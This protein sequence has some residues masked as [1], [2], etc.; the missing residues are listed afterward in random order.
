MTL[1]MQ[2]PSTEALLAEI[3]ALR[4]EVSTLRREKADMELLVEMTVEYSDDMTEDLRQRIHTAQQ[5]SMRQ[6]ELLINATPVP[7]V[8]SRIAGDQ[9]VYANE[10]AAKLAGAPRAEL[11]GHSAAEFYIVPG[12]R[13]RLLAAVKAQG[14]VNNWEAEGRKGDNTLFW[15]VIFVRQISFRG[16]P[17]LLEAYHNRTEQK[18]AEQDR[19]RL[20]QQVIEAQRQSLQEL[21]SPIIPVIDV[22]ETG[23]II[24]VP[25]IGDIDSKRAQDITRSLLVGI[26]EHRA[27]VVILDITGVP[28]VNAD[29]A[30]H[31]NRTIQAARLKGARTIVTGVSDAVAE[32]IVDLGIDWGGIRTLGDLQAGLVA[33]LDIV[34]FKLAR[35]WPGK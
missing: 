2:T 33:A 35:V 28:V 26:T 8:V 27:K 13:E 4:E 5:E 16:E 20:Q 22:P 10:F 34:G 6:F 19:A 30:D 23:G 1:Q 9:I 32:T 7:I 21:S 31:L 15:A 18:R 29:I 14:M 12:E 3:A 25:L 11:R 24:V 17:C